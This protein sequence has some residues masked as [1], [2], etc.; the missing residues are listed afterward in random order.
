MKLRSYSLTSDDSTDPEVREKAWEYANGF[1]NKGTKPCD[2]MLDALSKTAHAASVDFSAFKR[3][4]RAKHLS[5]KEKWTTIYRH[6]NDDG[7]TY[8]VRS[9]VLKCGEFF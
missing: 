4:H 7:R 6:V 1:L 8:L 3:K 2:S 5:V 9:S